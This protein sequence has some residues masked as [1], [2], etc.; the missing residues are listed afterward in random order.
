MLL[1]A[2]AGLCLAMLLVGCGLGTAATPFPQRLLLAGKAQGG[3]Q[4]VVGATVQLYA[5]GTTGPASAAIPTLVTP[6]L[7]DANGSFALS[8]DSTCGAADDQ[9]YVTVTGGNPGLRAGRTNPAL[10]LVAAL[11]RCG[12]LSAAPPIIVNEVTT[13]AAAWALAPFVASSAAI[14]TTAGNK[15]GL[16]NA[17]QNSHRIADPATGLPPRL[18]ATQRLESDKVLALADALAS[19]VNSDGGAGCAPLF[20]A[21]TPPGGTAPTDTF[22]AALAVVRH[23][24]HNVEGVWN[25]ITPQPPFPPK[26]VRAP[27]DWTLSLTL[28]GGG[29]TTPTA[30]A[31]DALGNVWTTSTAGVLSAFTPQGTPFNS[32]GFGQGTLGESYGLAIDPSD[33]VWVSVQKKPRHGATRGGLVRFL[34]AS[35]GATAG[36]M[37]PNGDSNFYADVSMNYPVGIFADTNGNILMANNANASASV[38][39]THGLPIAVYLGQNYSPFPTAVAAD[40]T[41]GVWIANEGDTTLTHVALDGTILETPNCCLGADA[42]ALDAQGNVW[43]AN[44]YGASVSEVS[45][46]GNVLLN[47]VTGGGLASPTGIAVDGGGTVWVANYHGGS[48]SQ[49]AGSTS[50][51]PGAVLSPAA[52]FGLDALLKQPYAVAPDRSGTLWVSDFAASDVVMFFGLAAPTVTPVQPLATAP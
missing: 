2:G 16:A 20:S 32:T 51:V 30:L 15:V 41:H 38:Y 29:L 3:Q 28:T 7:S 46:T 45:S 22:A 10:L 31:V 52:G 39:D 40:A 1:A 42:L 49:L 5:A 37:V 19:C 13:A 33:N 8:G 23:P 50:A 48:V 24:G 12:D 25:A 47:G 26:L 21:A 44:F 17:F 4:A 6:L 11:G 43:A 27:H 18:P 9:M 14:G 34:G 35:A 36:T